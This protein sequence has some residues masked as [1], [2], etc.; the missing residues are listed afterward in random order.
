MTFGVRKFLREIPVKTLRA[1]FESKSAPVPTEWWK[2][3]EPKLISKL[4]D[5]L[6]SGT[7]QIGAGILAEMVRIHP[8]ASER[9]RNALLN[10]ASHR[11]EFVEQFGMLANDHERALWA[12]MAHSDIFREGEELCFF[13]YYSEG[14]RGRQLPDNA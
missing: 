12:L 10:A 3:K 6:I 13:D 9:G 5:Y 14:S 1:Y 7:D 4:A 11:D 8:M 2:H